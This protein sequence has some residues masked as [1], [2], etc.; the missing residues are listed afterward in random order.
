MGLVVKQLNAFRMGCAV[1]PST[2]QPCIVLFHAPVKD[3]QRPFF[4]EIPVRER[5]YVGIFV[6]WE[7]NEWLGKL[8]RKSIETTNNYGEGFLG[9][10]CGCSSI[11]LAFNL[12][13]A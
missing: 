1:G 6:H 2:Q 9:L 13:S 3:S 12:V 11:K 8:S 4:F 7:W 10:L 5:N